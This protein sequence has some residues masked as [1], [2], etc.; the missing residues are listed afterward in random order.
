MSNIIVFNQHQLIHEYLSMMWKRLWFSSL[1]FNN[2]RNIS[3]LLLIDYII[4]Q[5]YHIYTTFDLEN[6]R[7]VR[8]F[9]RLYFLNYYFSI[10][11]SN[12]FFVLYM[13]I[14]KVIND[15][16]IRLNMFIIKFMLIDFKKVY[17]L[18]IHFYYINEYLFE[19]EYCRF[20]LSTNKILEH[21][22]YYMTNEHMNRIS[23]VYFI[24]LIQFTFTRTSKLLSDL[25]RTVKITRINNNIV[26]V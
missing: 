26:L 3:E 9:Y 13:F 7:V 1:Q 10:L 23:F 11:Q 16:L 25:T 4:C 8:F 2:D 24:M 14:Y 17:F 6:I 20:I 19:L 5:N 21:F 22:M 18:M 15:L 12:R